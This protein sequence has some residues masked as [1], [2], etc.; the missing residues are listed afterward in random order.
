MRGDETIL[1]VEDEPL[2]LDLATRMLTRLGYTV[3]PAPTP[4]EA[5]ELARNHPGEIPLLFTDVVMPEMSGLD[6][7]KAI[8]PL[9]PDITCLYM[10]G[11]S[12][13]VIT[14]NGVL[15][16]GVHFIQKPFVLNDLAA[17]VRQTLDGAARR[18]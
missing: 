2:I 15:D 13:N 1:L 5:L 14:Q 4:S 9:H 12:S 16:E 8:E 6:L 10:S 11:Y 3:L 18:S 7:L 17:K